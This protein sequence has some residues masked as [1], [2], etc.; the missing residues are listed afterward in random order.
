[1]E[2][3]NVKKEKREKRTSLSQSCYVT[4]SGRRD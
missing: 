2:T 3:K 1:M 4:E